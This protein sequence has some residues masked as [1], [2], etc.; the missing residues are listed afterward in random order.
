MESDSLETR[1]LF[2]EK[3]MEQVPVQEKEEA[4]FPTPSPVA[5]HDLVVLALV[6]LAGF[7]DVVDF[8]FVQ[9]ALP[10]VRTELL[11]S[12]AESQWIVG[13]YGLTMAGFLMLSGRA[14]DVYGQK[15]LFIIGIVVFT[16][17][18]LTGGLA[19]SLLVLV[20]SRGVQGVGAAISSATAL[21]ILTAT[22]PE[23]RERNRALGIFV[24]V[25]TAGFASGTIA[26][27]VLTAR[28]GWRS[29][30]FVNV[31]IGAA[32]VVLSQR[33]LPENGGR[34]VDRR[35]DLPGALSVTSG[36][37][38][39]VYGLT[40]AANEGFSSLQTILPVGLSA[41]IL[42][43]FLVIEYRSEAPLVPLGFLRRGTVLTANV[44]A[45]IVNSSAGGLVFLLTIYL[46]Q[47]LGYSALSAG[48]G[49]LPPAIIFFVVGGW[50]SPWLVDRVGTKPVLVMSM[51]LITVG[52]ALLTQIS[53]A[54]GY[55]CILPGLLIW[56]FGASLSFTA[57]NI[58][59]LAG[60]KPGEE[61]LASGL[62]STS[63]RIGL[64]LG[65]ALLLTVASA[66]DPQPLGVDGPSS[67]AAVVGGFHYA[68]LASAILSGIGL[69][70]ALLIR[71]VKVARG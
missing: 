43:G 1:A 45:L 71:H 14:G 25:L 51:A 38:L 48:L 54:G 30:M 29:V 46:Q 3:I 2:G 21:S 6:I 12:L 39:L 8:S 70:I 9:V 66:T 35:L 58:A 7:L 36:L 55:F 16:L 62:I 10:T 60:T 18:S 26:G 11:V 44:L 67:V 53:V 57:F 42:V 32:A 31:P 61:G 37:V 49:L 59:G 23:G 19:P 56:G 13:A 69:M 5:S 64:P 68:F 34:A 52:S 65:L 50:G 40:N 17:A 27:G 28:L 63:M 15:R 22:F 41:L 20:I 4:R 47:I 33:F 24:A